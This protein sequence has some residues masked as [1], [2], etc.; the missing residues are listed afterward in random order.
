[1]GA[2]GGGQLHNEWF[3][4]ILLF[5]YNFGPKIKIVYKVLWLPYFVAFYTF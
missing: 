1:M 2:G 4:N 3:L 5:I